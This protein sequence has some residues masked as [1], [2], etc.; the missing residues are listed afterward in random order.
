VMSWQLA[1][2]F[3]AMGFIGGITTMFG[4]LSGLRFTIVRDDQAPD[5]RYT[6][7]P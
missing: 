3:I 5:P 2:I 6:P 7:T 4:V 1:A